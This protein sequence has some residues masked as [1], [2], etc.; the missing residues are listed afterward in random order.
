[1][2][3]PRMNKVQFR[4]IGAI[5]VPGVK[6]L[7]NNGKLLKTHCYLYKGMVPIRFSY[8]SEAELNHVEIYPEGIAVIPRGRVTGIPF[9]AYLKERLNLSWQDFAKAAMVHVIAKFRSV[10]EVNTDRLQEALEA[11]Y[12][13]IYHILKGLRYEVHF[14]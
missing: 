1:M 12:T 3:V 5:E 13:E 10:K 2:L 7:R 8:D 4:K 14:C 11:A 6:A 9:P